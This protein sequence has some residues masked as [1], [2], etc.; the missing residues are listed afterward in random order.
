MDDLDCSRTYP[1]YKYNGSLIVPTTAIHRYSEPVITCPQIRHLI[2]I[3][4]F[5]L[6]KLTGVDD[7]KEQ[8]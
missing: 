4:K 6:S 5:D 1:L 3:T 8:V 2:S 7:G